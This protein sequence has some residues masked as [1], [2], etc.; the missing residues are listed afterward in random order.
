MTIAWRLRTEFDKHNHLFL[1]KVDTGYVVD[2]YICTCGHTKFITKYPEQRLSY[3][4]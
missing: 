2:T 4:C 3:V 1:G